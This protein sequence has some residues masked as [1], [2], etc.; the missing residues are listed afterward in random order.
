MKQVIKKKIKDAHN[1]SSEPLIYTLL[2]DG[3]AM[4]KRAL[5]DKRI[6]T[7]NK[8][9]G[10][11]FQSLIAMGNILSKR[12]FNFCYMFWD[13]QQSGQLRFEM[14][15]EYKA[16]R[17][18]HYDMPN[19]SEYDKKINDFVKKVLAYSKQK[20]NKIEKRR[21]ET[22]EETF[23]NQ[24][25]LLFQICE[26]LFIRS[27]MAEKYVEGDDLIAYY[28]KNKK[29]NEKIVIITGDRDL[30]QL[31][32]D[33]VAIYLSD[34]KKIISSENDIKELG[35]THKN[36]VI[37]KM[38]CGDVSDNIKGIKSMGEKTFFKHFPKAIKEQITLDEIITTAKQINEE[39]TKN[40]QKPLQVLENVV[41][42]ITEGSQGTD[43]YEINKKIID[44]SEPLLTKEA[45]NDVDELMYAPLDPDGRDVKNIY[46]IV[47]DNGMMDILKEETFSK[48][49]APFYKLIDNEKKYYKKSEQ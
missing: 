46:Q 41:N 48:L 39:R 45:K 43:I 18:K 40:K 31:I 15:P 17:D 49:F 9:Y 3:N 13:A 30:T 6:G 20:Q 16:N 29:P 27:Y 22:E 2:I 4:L 32:S 37:K 38:L 26:N 24:R 8:E 5:V 19:V 34:I 1:I 42:K 12:D 21:D 35:Y 47:K 33:D 23:N 25:D 14:Y 28:V 44:L 7:N 10:A 11:I 36:V